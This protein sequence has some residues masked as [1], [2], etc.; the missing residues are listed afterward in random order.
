MV[1]LF[2]GSIAVAGYVLALYFI[3][4]GD[5]VVAVPFALVGA[6]IASYMI[7]KDLDIF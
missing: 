7:F 3:N 4:T 6:A 1:N 2:L 5:G